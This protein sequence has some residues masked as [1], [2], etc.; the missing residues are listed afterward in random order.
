MSDQSSSG[1]SAIGHSLGAGQDGVTILLK[2]SGPLTRFY[3]GDFFGKRSVTV[4]EDV[5]EG[6]IRELRL[7]NNWGGY[8]QVCAKTARD[9]S[10]GEVV[11]YDSETGLIG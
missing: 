4:M 9:L 7:V 5:P 6:E 3:T 2:Q 1:G 8:G 10:K 11:E